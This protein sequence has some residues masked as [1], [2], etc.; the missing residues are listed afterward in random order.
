MLA[1]LF[2]SL[3]PQAGVPTREE[4]VLAL[5]A[6]VAGSGTWYYADAIFKA[7][8][9][10]LGSGP[11]LVP[12]VALVMC[13][14][15]DHYALEDARA[16]QLG[17]EL[18]AIYGLSLQAERREAE[19]ARSVVLD[20]LDTAAGLGFELRG[21]ALATPDV[22]GMGVTYE[23]GEVE[24]E[25][26]SVALDGDEFAWLSARGIR[27]HVADVEA[28][29][30]SL[31][32]F[33]PMLAY[34][35][36]LVRFL[37]DAT[38]GENV[39]LGGLL[40]EREAAWL[41]RFVSG[42]GL[43]VYELGYARELVVERATTLTIRCSGR[44]DLQAAPERDTLGFYETPDQT[45]QRRQ[46]RATRGAPAALYLEGE[47]VADKSGEPRPDFR[48]RFR[49]RV[50][51]STVERESHGAPLFLPSSV[52]LNEPFELELELSPG[53][54]RFDRI[55]LGTAAHE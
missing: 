4:R 13:G 23:T 20:G 21:H 34:L 24:P 54:Y 15:R 9:P 36:S 27:L 25:D 19:G 48:V 42:E 14:T 43:R 32:R 11:V 2:A 35:A 39:E 7:V 22:G 47:A 55:H 38:P 45:L 49:Q 33:T 30:G 51:G 28:Y 44:A 6:E 1:L 40:F 31:E 8:E 16:R 41:P 3:L 29:R 12:R 26:A 53:R 50:D 18:F 17:R 46:F 10:P 37:N 5:L 52:E